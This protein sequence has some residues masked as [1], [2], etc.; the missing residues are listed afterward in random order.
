[1]RL[2]AAGLCG[3]SGAICTALSTPSSSSHRSS[4]LGHKARRSSMQGCSQPDRLAPLSDDAFL[5]LNTP[6]RG[7][8]YPRDGMDDDWPDGPWSATSPR[9]HGRHPRTDGRITL[10]GSVNYAKVEGGLSVWVGE[11]DA[12]LESPLGETHVS[13]SYGG[14]TN[15]QLEPLPDGAPLGAP[16]RAIT[17]NSPWYGFGWIPMERFS[18]KEACLPQATR[19]SERLQ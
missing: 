7:Q 19:P 12:E 8:V 17:R 15:T 10:I 14:W 18:G 13:E 1:V 2:T 5:F 9:P 11:V 6:G 3:I 16:P 4:A